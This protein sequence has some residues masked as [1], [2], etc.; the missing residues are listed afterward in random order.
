M[1][2]FAARESRDETA[3]RS[4]DFPGIAAISVGLTALVLALVEGNSWGWGST[5][6][7]APA[8]RRGH[9]VRR[10]RLIEP[11]MRVP[12]VDFEFFRSRT[13]LGA[14]VVAFVVSFAMLAMFFFLALYMQNILG[15]RRSRPAC[16]S[17]PRR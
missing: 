9:R 15:F 7:L 14:N 5:G 17:S 13:F 8:R 3:E 4:I 11:R 6:I 16:A 2:L 10:V 1:T 12:M